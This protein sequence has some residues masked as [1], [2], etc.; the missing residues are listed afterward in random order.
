VSQFKEKVTMKA[1]GQSG[2][3]LIGGMVLIASL[4]LLVL[5]PVAARA[6]GLAPTIGASELSGS[7]IR[8][9]GWHFVPGSTVLVQA[10]DAADPS[11]VVGQGT[12]TASRF[13]P[14]PPPCSPKPYCYYLL[15]PGG[16]IN[17]ALPLNLA[18]PER[19]TVM[20]FDLGYSLHS[21]RVTLGVR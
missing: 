17:L 10:R 19:V 20:A 13:V 1:F 5:Q 18:H 11:I 16:T 14:P 2:K 4:A 7:T 12:T 8:V 15:V 21:N 9:V 6:G 3:R